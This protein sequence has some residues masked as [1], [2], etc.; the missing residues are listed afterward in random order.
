[1][2]VGRLL[3]RAGRLEH[4]RAFLEAARPADEEERI[5]RLFLLGRIEMRLGRP[6]QAA[7]RFEEILVL[8]PGLTRVRLEL[9][10]AYYLAGRDDKARHH[11]S[12]SLAEP[13]PSSVETAVEG[14]L[15]RID[16]RKRWSVSVSASVLPET[17]RPE[18]ET[19]RIG[20]VPFRLSEDARASSGTGGFFSAGASYSPKLTETLHGVLGASA[21]AKLYRGSRWDDVTASGDAGLSRLFVAGSVSGGVR[22]GRRWIGG[23]GDQRSMGPWGRVRWRITNTTRLDV[24][25]SAGYRRHDSR[26]DRDGW[27]LVARPRIVHALDGRTSIEAEPQFEIVEAKED[28]HASRLVGLGLSATRAFEG[29]LSITVDA[30]ASVLRHVTPD[31]LFGT[32]R[33]DRNERVG[34]RVLHRSLRYRGFAPYVGWS[35]ERNRSNIPIHE[36]RIRGVLVGITRRF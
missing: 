20:G 4:A 21:A 31:P 25:L 28:R 5:E 32:R 18:R 36:F 22:L 2:Q 30:S 10:S 26:E 7:E 12:S 24:D 35:V 9:A 34:V 23:E 6:E 27:R 1:M 15:R 8:R 14:F 16:A 3:I 33:V 19:V 29:G 11:F 13:L 17:K